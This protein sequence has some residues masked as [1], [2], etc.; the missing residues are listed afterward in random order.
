[1]RIHILLFAIFASLTLI[2]TADEKQKKST[3]PLTNQDI[4]ALAGC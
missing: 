3:K 2:V 1:M 4:V